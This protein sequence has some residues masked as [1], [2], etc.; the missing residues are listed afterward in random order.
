VSEP[1]K[2]M[3]PRQHYQAATHLITD[4]LDDLIK[5]VNVSSDVSA[6]TLWKARAELVAVAQVHATLATVPQAQFE[7]WKTPPAE[8]RVWLPSG[9]PACEH[10]RNLARCYE[11]HAA[12]QPRVTCG[13][14][15]VPAWSP[16][17]MPGSRCDL[18]GCSGSMVDWNTSYPVA[19]AP[20]EVRP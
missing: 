10:G 19:M 12:E 7:R 14:C 4:G 17:R 13:A 3:S 18:P 11:C 5:G 20:I 2:M 8:P 15:W 1:I 9:G 6:E 16:N